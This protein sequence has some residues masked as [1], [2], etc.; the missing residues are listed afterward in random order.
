PVT[1]HF[2]DKNG[3]YPDG[4]QVVVQGSDTKVMF[5][6]PLVCNRLAA[7]N[8]PL[9]GTDLIVLGHVHEDHTAGLHR[10]PETPV[11]APDADLA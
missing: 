3:K 6:T 5:D 4:N 11:L 9:D 1:V 7:G 10:F 8:G 2:G